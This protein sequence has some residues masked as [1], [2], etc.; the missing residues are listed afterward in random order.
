LRAI[1]ADHG[2]NDWPEKDEEKILANYKAW[3]E[4]ARKD[5]GF[6]DLAMVV[7]R[8]SPP[9]G[10][11]QVRRVQERMIRDHPHCFRG[12]D[13]DTLAR[14]DT[15]DRIHLSESGATKAARLWAD[16]LDTH[17]FQTAKPLRAR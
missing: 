11:G 15:T 4:Q 13:Y 1:L 9:G 2:Q 17:F 10:S 3:I 12:P 7:N 14:E 6:P 8:Q 16:A 5:T